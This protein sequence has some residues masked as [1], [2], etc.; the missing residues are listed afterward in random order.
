MFF[1]K[2][3]GDPGIGISFTTIIVSARFRN[4]TTGGAASGTAVLG[5]VMI[6]DRTGSDTET[7][8][9]DAQ[10]TNGDVANPNANDGLYAN[11]RHFAR[12]PGGDLNM[13][14]N[15]WCIVA[16]DVIEDDAVGRFMVCGRGL[17]Q[18]GVAATGDFLTAVNDVVANDGPGPGDHP[19]S[20]FLDQIADVIQPASTT[21]A[22]TLLA[23]AEEASTGAATNQRCLFCGVGGLGTYVSAVGA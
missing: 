13:V 20:S 9:L 8:S 7:R 5:E 17:V 23:M 22:F 12:L 11:V 2:G 10:E 6:F 1:A 16:S 14:Q 19:T 15:L 3:I 21:V 4:N 18:T